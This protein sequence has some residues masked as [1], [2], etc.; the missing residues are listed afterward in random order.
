MFNDTNAILAFE[1]IKWGIEDY[2]AIELRKVAKK[3]A[4]VM[5]GHVPIPHHGE[6]EM[7]E[8]LQAEAIALN[9]AEAWDIAHYLQKFDDG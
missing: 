2:G 7:T 1:R 6:T 3:F 9:R 8:S 4:S 5:G